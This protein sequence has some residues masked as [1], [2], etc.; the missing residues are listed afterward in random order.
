MHSIMVKQ[1]M[2]TPLKE[3]RIIAYSV[4]T[5]EIEIN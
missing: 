5:H 2:S 3:G 1:S 4:I